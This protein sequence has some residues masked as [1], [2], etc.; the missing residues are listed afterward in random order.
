MA[1]NVSQTLGRDDEEPEQ[2]IWDTHVKLCGAELFIF[3]FP[4]VFKS[5][6][7]CKIF[8]ELVSFFPPHL[9]HQKSIVLNQTSTS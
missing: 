6:K 5:R 1:Q 8:R 3:H 9:S 7:V 4:I 2:W